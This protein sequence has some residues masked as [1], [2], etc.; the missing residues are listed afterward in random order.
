MSDLDVDLPWLLKAK[1]HG[2][3]IYSSYTY[4]TP[5]IL[6]PFNI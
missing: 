5:D 4:H 1:R 6:F 2:A 3:I